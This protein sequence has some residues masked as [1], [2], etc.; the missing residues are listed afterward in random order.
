M[1]RLKQIGSVRHI[2]TD[3]VVANKEA[4]NA[5]LDHGSKLNSRVR[6]GHS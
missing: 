6:A 5:V 2:E 3:A 1:E 4:R